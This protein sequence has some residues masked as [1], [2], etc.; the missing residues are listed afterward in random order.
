M[1]ATR[2]VLTPTA[3]NPINR[4]MRGRG[5]GRQPSPRRFYPGVVS[6]ARTICTQRLAGGSGWL[7]AVSTQTLRPLVRHTPRRWS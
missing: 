7:D 1:H 3:A 4:L 6:V 5:L 2:N